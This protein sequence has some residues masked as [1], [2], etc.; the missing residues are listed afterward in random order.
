MR[1]G[2]TE[3]GGAVVVDL[4]LGTDAFVRVHTEKAAKDNGAER[5]PRLLASMPDKQAAMLV[6]TQKQLLGRGV[7]VN[8]LQE[9]C[10]Q[11]DHANLW[12]LEFP[13]EHADAA[14]EEPFFS[15]RY[16]SDR[17]NLQPHRQVR[18]G[19]STGAGAV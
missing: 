7:D 2:I 8:L 17:I 15:D 3:E 12:I 9:A 13:L 4:A 14:D 1:I 6:V 5:L 19:L 16:S 10:P 18:V 11:A